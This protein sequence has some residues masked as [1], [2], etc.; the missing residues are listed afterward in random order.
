MEEGKAVKLRRLSA[1]RNNLPHV[2]ASALAA[3]L[4]EA[5]RVGVPEVH[6][7][8]AVRESRDEELSSATC[9][10]GEPHGPLIQTVHLEAVDGG[11]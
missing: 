2:S 7:R 11:S 8:D 4:E 5:T 6:N 1:F 9:A 10:T 3:V